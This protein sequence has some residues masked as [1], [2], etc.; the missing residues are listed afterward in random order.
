MAKH[1]DKHSEGHAPS[2]DT[3]PTGLTGE[4][5]RE[6][7]RR[8]MAAGFGQTGR[9]AEADSANP[10][11][12]AATA[13]TSEKLAD[14]ALRLDAT[15]AAAGAP[16]V[17]PDDLAI[18]NAAVVELQ[19]YEDYLGTAEAAA[20]V[21]VDVPHASQTGTTLCCTMG[22]WEGEPT[23]YSYQWD[24]GGTYADHAAA[25][26]HEVLPEDVGKVASCIVSATNSQGTTVAPASNPVTI[27]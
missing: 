3:K 23:A 16:P 9:T 26:E 15:L 19:A 4:H 6:A 8:Q 24:I 12:L 13:P 21:N 27:A 11:P 18:L 20:P 2:H 5:G 1:E 7:S 17:G 14:L 25:A 22:N 10:G